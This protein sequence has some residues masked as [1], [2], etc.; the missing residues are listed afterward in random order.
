MTYIIDEFGCEYSDDKKEFV[1]CPKNYQGHYTIQ[2]GV[3][4]IGA[5][6][7][8]GC[9]G[10]K[11]VT[12]PNSVTSIGAWAFDGTA[13][14]ANQSDG[15]IYIN[16]M[17]YTYKG[18][19]P[20]NTSIVVRDG[21]TQI[22]DSAFFDCSGLT[23]VTIPNSVTSIGRSAFYYCS[24]LTS[25]TIPNSVTSIGSSAFYG[26]AWLANQPDGVIYI[27]QSLYTY[28]GEMPANTSI[29]VR[30]GT[31]QIC[32]GAFAGCSTLTSVTIP[33]SVT[34]IGDW[35]FEDCSGLTSVT[36]P[37]SVTSIGVRAFE[38]C[39]GLTSV[40]IGN[41]VTS[42][43]NWAFA[44]ASKLA[45]ITVNAVTPPT[46]ETKTFAEVDRTIPVV[47]P[48]GSLSQYKADIYWSKFI[49]ISEALAAY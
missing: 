33:N 35:A 28:K 47:V 25:V 17:L 30:D 41:S 45:K 43:E 7:F 36:I 21:T 39:S 4:S 9:S 18:E 26:T 27:N 15:V 19:M 20:A 5:W 23:S 31:T 48:V 49:N 2:E 42:I 8:Y 13:W 37:N 14:L 10:L 12:I 46:I 16:Q 11:S 22:C 3:T 1:R 24:G 34:S 44:S 38:D 29:V 40:T 32:G 6:A